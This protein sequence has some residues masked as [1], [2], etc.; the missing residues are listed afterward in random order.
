VGRLLPIADRHKPANKRHPSSR[1]Q[2][3]RVSLQPTNRPFNRCLSC[4]YAF[5]ILVAECISHRRLHGWLACVETFLRVS[6]LTR[7]RAGS[8]F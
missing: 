4:F 3:I 8:G 7:L 6:L 5:H 2:D 1:P